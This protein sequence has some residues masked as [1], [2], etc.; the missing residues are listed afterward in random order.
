M[1][2]ITCFLKSILFD[3]EG[4]TAEILCVYWV[5]MSR[6]LPPQQSIQKM[7][8]I[9]YK[10]FQSNKIMTKHYKILNDSAE[11]VH[12]VVF[13]CFN[14][15]IPQI[16]DLYAN[17]FIFIMWTRYSIQTKISTCGIS[18]IGPGTRIRAHQCWMWSVNYMYFLSVSSL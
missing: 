11:Y 10:V 3:A 7:S 12:R 9:S 14:L 1:C 17:V 4:D 6:I 2:L 18:I 8:F 13:L 15:F 16:F 5:G